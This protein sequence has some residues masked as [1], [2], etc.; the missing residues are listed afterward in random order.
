MWEGEPGNSEFASDNPDVIRI[1]EGGRVE[2]VDGEP[3]LKGYATEE[4]ILADM[5]GADADFAAAR[6][7]LMEQYP[8]R[9]RNA[10][11]V[12]AWEK[13]L[14]PDLWGNELPEQHTWHHE[15]DVES[16]SLVPTALH[17]NIPHIGGASPAR[18]GARPQRVPVFS[19][20][21]L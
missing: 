14:E 12:E 15:P 3:V 13:G 7:G 19:S 5:K 17:E 9:W 16:M 10:T 20:N 8:E 11:H 6:R 18:G 2:F 4:V 21:P 1:T